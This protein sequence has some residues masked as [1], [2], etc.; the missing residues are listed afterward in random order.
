MKPIVFH[1]IAEAELEEAVAFYEARRTGIGQ[2]LGAEA[3]RAVGM[4]QQNPLWCP[5]HGE[6]NFRKCLLRKFPYTIFYMERDDCIWI[7]AVA[8]QKRKPGYWENR[9]P[10]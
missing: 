4:I 9:T 3:E 5:R 8:H 2:A 10:D 6:T 7:A 1:P